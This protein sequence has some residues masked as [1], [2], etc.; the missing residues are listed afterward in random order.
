MFVG[1]SSGNTLQAHQRRARNHA[2]HLAVLSFVSVLGLIWR[3]VIVAVKIMRPRSPSPL[4]SMTS[5]TQCQD[6][7]LMRLGP[8]TLGPLRASRG[9]ALDATNFNQPLGS[10]TTSCVPKIFYMLRVPRVPLDTWATSSVTRICSRRQIFNQTPWQLDNFERH[11]DVL[12]VK[13]PTISI[14]PP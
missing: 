14:R 1:H 12:H 7:E 8:L 6:G 3:S 4:I 10:W 9:V 5:W 2:R 13:G 11:K